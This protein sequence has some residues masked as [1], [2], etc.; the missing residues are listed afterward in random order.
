[1]S[2]ILAVVGLK[3][4]IP[5]EKFMTT[6]M[7]EE[8]KV[9][10]IGEGRFGAR[11][12]TYSNGVRAILKPKLHSTD[13]FREIPKNTQ[14]LKEAAAY[15]LDRQLLH[16]DV[17]P[18]TTLTMFKRRPASMQLYV[19]GYSARELEPHVFNMSLDKWKQRVAKFATKVNVRQ[20]RKLVLF[21]IITN[22]TDRHAKNAMFDP[23]AGKVW[24]IDN[25]L[26][27]GKQFRYYN[28][29]FH[30]FLYRRKL[31]LSKNEITLLGDITFEQL[32]TV[33]DRYLSAREV[34]ET[35]WRIQWMLE[36]DNLGF[37]PMAE[38]ME[39]K[40][41]FPSYSEWFKVKMKARRG[42]SVVVALEKMGHTA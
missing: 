10:K 31:K 7:T 13:K 35:Y 23:F 27:F 34:E 40:D 39:G 25:G 37:M 24:G 8:G 16:F 18:P 6:V 3:K 22:N 38:E 30:R 14:Y 11:E 20:M 19:M 41:E 21:D 1:M 9:K 42:N 36:Q 32:K 12:I 29:I 28:N 15:Q 2:D 33:L 26:C 4:S 5:H 17:V